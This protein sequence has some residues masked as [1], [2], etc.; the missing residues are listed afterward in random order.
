[1]TIPTRT[2]CSLTA[3]TARVVRVENRARLFT[4]LSLHL[5]HTTHTALIHTKNEMRTGVSRRYLFVP[6]VV[7]QF[8]LLVRHHGNLG[9]VGVQLYKLAQCPLVSLPGE[10]LP[11]GPE[12]GV[13][14]DVN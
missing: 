9:G 4:L 14:A 1:M 13:A 6:K 10:R 11:V 5:R 3:R 2:R 7:V 8:P 12:H